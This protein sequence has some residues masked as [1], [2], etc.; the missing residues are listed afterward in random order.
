MQKLLLLI[1][2]IFLSNISSYALSDCVKVFKIDNGLCGELCLSSYIATFA[3][4]FGGVTE[5]NCKDINYTIFDHKESISVGPFGNF[6]VNLYR[7]EEEKSLK[8]LDAKNKENSFIG[9]VLLG[10][11]V[12]VYKLDN[13]MCGELQLNSYIASFAE[14]FGGVTEGNCKDINYTIFDHNETVSVGPF[15]NFEVKIYRKD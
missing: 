3:V 12:T 10:G 11:D 2:I 8:F 14:K 15:G 5:G 6:E 7:K 1:S 13:G 9:K 4:K